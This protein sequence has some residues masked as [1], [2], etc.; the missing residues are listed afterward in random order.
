MK[1]KYFIF[2][3]IFSKKQNKNASIKSC[4]H[5]DTYF[6]YYISLEYILNKT[7]FSFQF[8]LIK[9]ILKKKDKT[10]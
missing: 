7:N 2:V 1:I 8:C 10:E 5:T 6:I 4:D 3:A 9:S